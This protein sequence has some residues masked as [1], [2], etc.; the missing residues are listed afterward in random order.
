MNIAKVNCFDCDR[1]DYY[2]KYY[3]TTVGVL[4]TENGKPTNLELDRPD[5][6]FDKINKV[7]FT[8]KETESWIRNRVIPNSQRGLDKILK[9]YNIS[10]DDEFWWWKLFLSTKGMNVK[11]RLYITDDEYDFSNPWD[12]VL[13]EDIDSDIS[14]LSTTK[15]LLNIDGACEKRLYRINGNL[16]IVKESLQDNT[17][18]GVAEELVYCICRKLGVDCAPAQYLGEGKCYSVIDENKELIHAGEF[19]KLDTNDVE[20]VVRKL[21]RMDVPRKTLVDYLRMVLVDLI[22]V[23]LDRN[24]TNFSFYENN[25]I[26]HLYR[27]YDNGLSLFSATRLNENLD[28]MYCKQKSSMVAFFVIKE[29]KKLNV[30]N[31]FNGELT[32]DFL[33]DLFS[34]FKKEYLTVRNINTT[35]LARNIYSRYCDIVDRY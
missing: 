4:H 15:A 11:D 32:L 33:H 25:G 5:L 12:M 16:A 31:V 26:V 2:L 29:M 3:N 27:L 23:Q 10:N 20:I 18:D 22:T 28:F 6:F 13:V 9:Q 24:M 1:K 35:E 8:K 17:I 34:K 30:S 19:L 14:N 21:K 7:F